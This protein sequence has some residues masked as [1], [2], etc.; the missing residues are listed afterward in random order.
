MQKQ[1]QS[2]LNI[3]LLD[4][5]IRKSIKIDLPQYLRP[6]GGKIIFGLFDFFLVKLP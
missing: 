3:F 5:F 6:F 2:L 1:N 4:F